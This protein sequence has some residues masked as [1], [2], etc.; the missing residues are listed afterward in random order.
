MLYHL[1]H[2]LSSHAP[3]CGAFDSLTLRAALAALTAFAV[4]LL[5][6]RRLIAYFRRRRIEENVDVKD[7]EKLAELH[8]AKARTPTMGGI[9]IVAALVGSTLLWADVTDPF[10]VLGLFLVSALGALGFW[11]DWVKLRGGGRKGLSIREKLLY[12]AAFSIAVA[13]SLYS[14]AEGAGGASLYVPLVKASLAVLPAAIY[15]PFAATVL[16]ATMNAVNFT[17][18]LD[19]LAAGCCAIAAV[20]L[21]LLA[22]ASGR[23]DYAA[24][25][26]I[27]F[28]HGAGELAVFTA[29]L[30][31][32][33]VGFLWFNCFPA[34]VFMGDTGSL[35]LGGA[36]GFLA[37]AV[38]QELLLLLV[39]GVFVAEG[40]SVVLQIL[41]FRLLGRRVFLIAP[42]HHRYQFLGWPESR[43]TIRFWIAGGVC[44]A[45]SV[46]LLKI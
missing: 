44:A 28:V 21:L 29:A 1:L 8:A 2:W 41:S 34:Q 37:C 27:P 31:G 6:G 22:Y 46:A 17:D 3:L 14:L 33:G 5:A 42:L 7:S 43:I 30:I 20:P 12:Q 16:V 11:D 45:A 9:G 24:H 15:I 18:G 25:L 36:V 39:G 32:A 38:R 13:A 40:L 19:G 26:A 35:P 10:V 4:S 23:P